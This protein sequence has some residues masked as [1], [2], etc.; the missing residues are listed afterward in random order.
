NLRGE[1]RF[2]RLCSSVMRRMRRSLARRK[3]IQTTHR[4]TSGCL[5]A[6]A[7][8]PRSCGISCV[9]PAFSAGSGSKDGGADDEQWCCQYV[10]SGALIAPLLF[11]SWF[12]VSRAVHNR[13]DNDFLTLRL[14]FIDDDVR[15]FDQLARP[16]IQAGTPHF[17]KLWS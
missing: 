14:H 2:G 16:R 12:S 17:G 11:F 7:R 4:S 15:V 3:L 8:Q 10:D 6:C 1:R 9:A 5:L 13:K